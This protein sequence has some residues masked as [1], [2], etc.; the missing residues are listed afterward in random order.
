MRSIL[1]MAVYSTMTLGILASAIPMLQA[2]ATAPAAPMS[3]SQNWRKTHP[4][5]TK[6][7]ARIRN[8]RRLL[9][10][11]LKAGKITKDQYRAQMKDLNTVKKEERV[12]AASNENGGH[13]TAGQQQAINGQLNDSRKDINQDVKNDKVNP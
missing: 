3:S 12:D 7:N 9:R 2:D 4:A 5:R 8:Q 10:Q 13:L 11:D 6:D 1:K